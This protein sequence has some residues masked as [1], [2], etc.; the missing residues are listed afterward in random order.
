MKFVFALLALAIA[1]GVCAAPHPFDVH[2]LVMMDRVSDPQISPDGTHVA[3][4]LRETDYAANKGATGIWLLDLTAKNAQP[5]RLTDKTVSANSPR[6]SSDSKSL[7]YLAKG[8]DAMQLWQQ[9]VAAGSKPVQAT[10]LALDVNNYKLSPSGKSVLLSLDVFTDCSD[11]ACTKKRLDDKTANKASGTLYDKVFIRH[12]DTWADGTRS[13]HEHPLPDGQG[14]GANQ[15]CRAGPA[16]TS[17]HQDD[18]QQARPQD[19]HDHDLEGQVRDD[20]HEVGEAH[21]HG[22]DP[23]TPVARHQA[24]EPADQDRHQRRREADQER[25]PGPVDQ[26]RQDV[27]PAVI[28]PKQVRARRR[29]VDVLDRHVC[30]C[31]RVVRR[32]DG[33]EDGEHER[34]HQHTEPDRPHRASRQAG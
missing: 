21:Q 7:Y 14:L 24:D 18:V 3:Y 8:G 29:L 5:V 19:C 27:V 25:H 4:Q 33:S 26:R 32:E 1:G 30:V 31:V 11:L 13:Q 12:W 17:D 15:P 23:A 10:A 9:A 20:Q 16:Q 22:P 28:G 34:H 6:W 2:D